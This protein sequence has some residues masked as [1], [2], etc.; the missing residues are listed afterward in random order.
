MGPLITVT[1]LKGLIC[2]GFI[3][4]ILGVPFLRAQILYY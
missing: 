4:G 3:M 2:I 1:S